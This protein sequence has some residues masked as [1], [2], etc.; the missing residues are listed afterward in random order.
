[1]VAKN[2]SSKEFS[3]L[4]DVVILDVRTPEEFAQ[5]HIQGAINI[6]YYADSFLDDIKALDMSKVYALYC[7]SG[8]R[9]SNAMS[10][11][12]SLGFGEVYN[13]IRG[14]IGW[15]AEQLPLIS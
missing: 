8:A 1:M 3:Q 7:R 5:E 4:V 12:A 2:I 6:D 14:I 13:L 9:S 15:K 10:L 11:M